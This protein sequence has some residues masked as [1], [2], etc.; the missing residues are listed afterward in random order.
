MKTKIKLTLI[1][2]NKFKF[3]AMEF[4]ESTKNVRQCF[5]KNM[6]LLEILYS[7]L[8]RIGLNL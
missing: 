6:E 2:Y 7:K 4:Q 1:S 5:L 8:D 3:Y